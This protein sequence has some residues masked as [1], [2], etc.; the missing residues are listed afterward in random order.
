MKVALI[1][2]GITPSF[3]Q[4]WKII[5]TGTVN[6]LLHFTKNNAGRVS[7][8]ADLLRSR[9]FKQFKYTLSTLTVDMLHLVFGS[10]SSLY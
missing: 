3:I 5:E 6:S 9:D 1:V 4:R 7:G 10:L 8:P 2:L